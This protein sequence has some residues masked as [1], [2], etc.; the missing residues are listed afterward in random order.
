[1]HIGNIS[2]YA[3][4]N[5]VIWGIEPIGKRNDAGSKNMLFGS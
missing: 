5:R 1:M 4:H 3:S 2:S